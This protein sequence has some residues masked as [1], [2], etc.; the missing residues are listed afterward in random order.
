MAVL[1][2]E[3]VPIAS[4]SGQKQLAES[5]I[6]LSVAG[7]DALTKR[8]G[9]AC[10]SMTTMPLVCQSDLAAFAM[11]YCQLRG[12]CQLSGAQPCHHAPACYPARVPPAPGSDA[13]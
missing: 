6:Q 5:I 2:F 12:T 11:T 8:A 4:G 7:V 9:T 1:N 3:G 13:E 10:R